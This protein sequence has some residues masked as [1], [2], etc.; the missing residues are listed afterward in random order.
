MEVVL[1]KQSIKYVINLT[2]IDKQRIGNALMKLKLEPP[3]GDIIKLTDKENEY[4]VRVGDLRILYKIKERTKA[5]GNRENYI[6][7][8]KIAPRGQIYKE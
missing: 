7:V 4:R 3:E 5:D 6:T 2:N 1:N 8:Y